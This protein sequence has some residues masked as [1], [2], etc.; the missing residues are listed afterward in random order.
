M[1]HS[2]KLAAETNPSLMGDSDKRTKF[3]A[4]KLLGLMRL[5]VYIVVKKKNCQHK[6]LFPGFAI[7]HLQNCDLGASN[8]QPCIL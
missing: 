1:D 2:E 6:L 8:K 4:F 7:R 5:I 3:Q